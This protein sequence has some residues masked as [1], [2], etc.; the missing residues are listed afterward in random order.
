MN[1]C[2]TEKPKLI[3][4]K[5]NSFNLIDVKENSLVLCDIDDTVLRFDL[6]LDDFYSSTEKYLKE[7]NDYLDDEDT[8]IIASNEYNDYRDKN[9]PFHTDKNGFDNFEKK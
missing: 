8:K 7:I 2:N 3:I 1:I 6:N 5:I 4:K 9:T